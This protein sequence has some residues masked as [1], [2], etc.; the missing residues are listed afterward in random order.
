MENIHVDQLPA[1]ST[2]NPSIA[3][4]IFLLIAG[5]LFGGIPVVGA[6]DQWERIGVNFHTFLLLIFFAVGCFFLYFALY[7]LTIREEITVN[8]NMVQKKSS[9]IFAKEEWSENI[10]N[11]DGIL[12][13]SISRQGEDEE[14][15]IEYCSI[16]K[17]RNRKKNIKIFE[18]KDMS[19]ARREWE[20]AIKLFQLPALEQLEGEELVEREVGDINKN[21]IELIGENKIS[22][23][24]HVLFEIP[25]DFIIEQRPDLL[26]ITQCSKMSFLN[27]LTMIGFFAGS[28][29][30]A[31]MFLKSKAPITFIA[32]IGLFFLIA[33]ILAGF[34][35]RNL[36]I[37]DKQLTIYTT[38]LNFNF[39][40]TSYPFEKIKDIKPLYKST[41]S[42][43]SGIKIIHDQGES[44]Y[45]IVRRKK[46]KCDWLR[47]LVLNEIKK[48]I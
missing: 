13:S 36:E 2:T 30:I 7:Q 41:G 46:E 1:K 38:F 27:Y 23:P 10:K 20:K 31:Q 18:S 25:R 16:L 39:G 5:L 45:T 21:V 43:M 22:F 12:F 17:H 26:F 32:G 42:S 33:S 28:S 37:K 29:Y 9:C 8:F 14:T 34:V 19:E 40:E 11:Y 4:G 15:Y 35:K 3:L 24:H 47:S 48:S 44:F 6:I